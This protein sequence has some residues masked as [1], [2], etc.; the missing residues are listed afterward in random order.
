MT[1]ASLEHGFEFSFTVERGVVNNDSLP[2][3]KLGD[4][5]MFEVSFDHRGRAVPFKKHGSKDL[6]LTPSSDHGYTCGGVS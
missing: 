4:Q 3:A 5:D 6:S 2:A 1:A